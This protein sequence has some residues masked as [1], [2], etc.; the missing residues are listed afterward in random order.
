M[1][2]THMIIFL[3]TNKHQSTRL[4]KLIKLSINKWVALQA[5]RGRPLQKAN[6]VSHCLELTPKR[7]VFSK[8]STNILIRSTKSKLISKILTVN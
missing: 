4:F 2:S 3:P 1:L 8:R 5:A 7:T 6:P